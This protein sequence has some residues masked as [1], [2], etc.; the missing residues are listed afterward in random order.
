MGSA[1][2]RETSK[3]KKQRVRHCYPRRELY[4][5]WIHNDKYVYSSRTYATS[6]CY[7]MLFNGVVSDYLTREKIVE[8][9]TGWRA[10]SCIAIINRD[11]RRIIINTKYELQTRELIY[12]IPDNYQVFLVDDDIPNPNI[13]STGELEQA[14]KLYARFLIKKFVKYILGES[15][16]VLAG[17]LTIAHNNVDDLFKLT[18]NVNHKPLEYFNNNLYGDYHVDYNFINAIVDYYKLK[19]Y[20]WYKEP[21][22]DKITV[23]GGNSWGK[24]QRLVVNTPSLQQVITNKVFTKREKEH[25]K[26][27]YFYGAYCRGNGIS[28]NEIDVN[29]NKPYDKT[30]LEPRFKKANIDINLDNRSELIYWQDGIKLYSNTIAANIKAE[31]NRCL[32][33]SALNEAKARLGFNKING[34]EVLTTFRNYERIKC[35]NYI[36]YKK[37]IPPHRKNTLGT[38]TVGRVYEYRNLFK[39]VQLRMRNDVIETSKYAT[40]PLKSAIAMWKLYKSIINK[41][42]WVENTNYIVRFD[43]KNIKIG[44]Y[45][46]RCIR[47]IKKKTDDGQVLDNFGWCISIGCHNIWIDDFMDFIKYYNLYDTFGIDKPD[48]VEVDTSNNNV[49]PL[50]IKIK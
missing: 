17:K 33:I 39:N 32:E 11:S 31:V 49:K 23:I 16:L 26:K 35:N 28:R 1:E 43:D 27:S 47:Y 41:H 5:Q 19:K 4:H 6:G 45:N 44:I 7:D 37:Y 3:I 20:S 22:N 13:L 29:W 14:L 8:Y 40:V 48:P 9:W 25:L 30:V 21:F 34:F 2:L 50:K 36:E 46:L 12:S 18:N 24:E 10:C 15:Y 38:W 42:E